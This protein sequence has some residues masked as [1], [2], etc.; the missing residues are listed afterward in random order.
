[1][2]L[3]MARLIF[4]YKNNLDKLFDFK[5]EPFIPSLAYKNMH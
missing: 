4:R 2:N 5:S 3:K 1:M